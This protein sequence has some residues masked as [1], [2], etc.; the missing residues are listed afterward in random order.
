MST[1][2]K[3]HRKLK[4]L[5]IGVGNVYRGDD[6][7][8]FFVAR[9]VHAQQL[10]ETKVIEESGEASKLL[11]LWQGVAT[12]VLVDAVSSGDRPGT[13]HR[14]E[15]HHQ[16][17][18]ARFFHFSTHSLGVAE[19]VEM[20]RVLKQLPQRLIVYGI[21][22]KNFQPGLGL[23]REV[24]GSIGEVLQAILKDLHPRKSLSERCSI[25]YRKVEF[26]KIERQNDKHYQN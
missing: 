18:P 26:P 19:A 6:A 11:S 9:A 12:V 25:G 4:A 10:P 14:F 22:G 13:I 5:V 3:E 23:S 16:E 15:A 24:Q 8:G 7:A 20:A 2:Y 21:E 17:I 1:Q